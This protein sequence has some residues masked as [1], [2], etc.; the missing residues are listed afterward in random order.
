MCFEAKSPV[1]AG[2]LLGKVRLERDLHKL[3]RQQDEDEDN[4]AV[5]EIV[6]VQ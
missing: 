2:Y 4:A 5:M 6:L 1:A 3:V